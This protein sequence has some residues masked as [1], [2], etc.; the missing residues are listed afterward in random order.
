M[1]ELENDITSKGWACIAQVVGNAEIAALVKAIGAGQ[2]AGSRR[3]GSLF[4][5][6][7]LLEVVPEVGELAKS[8][9]LRALVEP[10]L[11]PDCF[12]VR[13]I[14][15]DKT[16]E[17]NWNVLWHQDVTIAVR[18]RR[19]APGFACW[20]TK[21]GVP[22]VQ[23]PVGILENMLTVRLHLDD[24]GESNGPLRVVPGSHHCGRLN[25]EAIA[26][27]RAGTSEVSL[28]TQSGDAILMRPLLLHASSSASV[29]GHRRVIH[30]EYAAESLPFGLEWHARF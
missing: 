6:R 4:A 2:W 7:S 27:C 19:D 12:A 20:T 5:I 3:E 26:A 1:S 13:G 29:P 23:P 15:F 10:I 30:L 14:L 18:E 25:P 8:P 28:T 17:A 21:A 9:E 16:A 22:H 24:C 11:G